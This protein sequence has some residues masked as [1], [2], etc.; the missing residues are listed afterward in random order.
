MTRRSLAVSA[1]AAIV[2]GL[3]TVAWSA[4]GRSREDFPG[5]TIVMTDYAFSP[6]R[7]VWRAG[8]RVT[9]SVVNRSV[10][11]PAKVHEIMFGRG[12]RLKADAFGTAIPAGGFETP[13]LAGTRI[14]VE[15]G[16]ELSMLI[17]PGSQLS[18]VDPQS[19]VVP[20]PGM[21][22][23]EMPDQFMAM[24]A[25]RGRLTMS[26]VVPDRPGTWEFGCFQ[27]DG[28]HYRNGMRGSITIEPAR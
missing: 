19:L 17:A 14:E 5:T 8:Q 16:G 12:P 7:L 11:D 6:S 28:E 18:G 3:G 2:L 4:T 23:G 24:F 20:A 21:A 25:P 1:A 27:Q 15:G 26:F 13:L 9:L 22:M 10:A